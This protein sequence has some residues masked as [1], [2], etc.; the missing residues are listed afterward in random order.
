MRVTIG[1]KIGRANDGQPD[2]FPY[3]S[4]NTAFWLPSTDVRSALRQIARAAPY[5]TTRTGSLPSHAAATAFTFSKKRPLPPLT[6]EISITVPA[7][8]GVSK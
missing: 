3:A 6:S 7:C 8:P 2:Q 5:P 4:M 1:G